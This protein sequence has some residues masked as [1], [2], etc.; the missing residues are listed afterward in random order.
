MEDSFLNSPVF[1]AG[2]GLSTAAPP[3]NN[4]CLPTIYDKLDSDARAKVK[5]INCML[6][7]QLHVQEKIIFKYKDEALKLARRKKAVAEDDLKRILRKYPNMDEMPFV[8]IRM[9]FTK[10]R[11]KRSLG[12]FKAYSTEAIGM[13]GLSDVQPNESF[14]GRFYDH[15]LVGIKDRKPHRLEPET[16]LSKPF[17]LSKRLSCS[18]NVLNK[19]NR[20]K[21]FSDEF[22]D[23][24]ALTV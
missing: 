9:N 8:S 12:K 3:I 24:D 15:H 4:A 17:V 6:E 14:C 11:R 10:K 22:I 21:I 2:G 16:R 5:V 23:D 19:F 18:D 1:E 20:L 13:K 7:K